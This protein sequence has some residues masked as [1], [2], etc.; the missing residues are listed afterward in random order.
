MDRVEAAWCP[1]FD[2]VELN[3]LRFLRV[4]CGLRSENALGSSLV[5]AEGKIVLDRVRRDVGVDGI[6][7]LMTATTQRDRSMCALG[8]SGGTALCVAE[9]EDKYD[10]IWSRP[11]TV[12][13]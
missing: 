9:V 10:T 5:M 11:Q 2:I 12:I 1:R 7:G 4:A 8:R 13:G 3:D 6:E